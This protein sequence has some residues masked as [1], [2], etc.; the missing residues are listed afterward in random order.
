MIIDISNRLKDMTE[1]LPRAFSKLPRTQLEVHR[2]PPAI[3]L[4]APGAYCLSGSVDGTRPGIIYFNQHDLPDW[5]KWTVATTVY[6]EGLPGHHLQGSLA[7]EA[8]DIPTLFKLLS[9]TAAAEGWAL[10]AEQL[11]DELGAY[12]ADPLGRLGML[13]ASLFRAC[14]I[15][16]DTG[17]HSQGWT[18]ERAIAY[19]IDQS[20]SA[21]DDAR[22]EIER[23]ISWPGQACAYKIGQ[24]E[25]LRWR[26][27]AKQRLGSRFDIRG[28]HKVVLAY[29]SLP[30]EVLS[31]AVDQWIAASEQGSAH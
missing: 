26:E 5:P 25:I 17:L 14:R 30:L 28:F 29:G 24:L 21:P 10:Y 4:G 15:V 1:R 9:S 20:G 2:V 3:E 8:S 11:A 7:N 16:V 18:R 6:H 31:G 19:L 22:R 23:Y 12:D 13:Q 27:R